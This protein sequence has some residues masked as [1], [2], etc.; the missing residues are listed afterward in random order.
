MTTVNGQAPAGRG[1]PPKGNGH[2]RRA[3][4]A[5]FLRTR[6]ERITPEQAGLPPGLR[7]RTPGL[8]REE[9]AQLAGV[10]VTWYTWL[11]QGRPINAS[12]QV[13]TAIARTLR[14]DNAEREHL[15]RLAGLPG[16]AGNAEA[17]SGCEQVPPEVRGILDTMVSLPASVL[18]E[19]F[20]L[21]AWNH[22]Y[23]AIWPGVTGARPGERNVLWLNFTNPGCCHPYINRDEQLPMMVAQLRANYG[24]HLGEP[25]WASFVR[26]M[27]AAS[28]YFAR[29]WEQHEVASST[30][31]LKVFRHPAF[32]RLVMTTTSLAV[33]SVPGTRVVVHT[34]ADEATR[35]A[36][37]RLIAGEGKDARYPCWEWHQR[38]LAA[39]RHT[40]TAAEQS[41]ASGELAL[42]AGEPAAWAGEPPAQASEPAAG[43]S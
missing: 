30:T 39:G 42:R 15:Y 26:R 1:N 4:L 2:T 3:E 20:D 13:L 5:A 27:Q 40:A 41:V 18:N 34:P 38:R 33:R 10:G 21:L 19:R 36:L 6:R 17:T 22:A 11:E 37:D 16:A 24:R 7:R 12:V 8:R 29:L 32:P 25:A 43:H 9:V 28:P 31:Y 23:A 14:L 35:D